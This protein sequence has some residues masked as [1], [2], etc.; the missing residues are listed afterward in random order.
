MSHWIRNCKCL[1]LWITSIG[2]QTHVF[3]QDKG[4]FW[5]Q[6]RGPNRDNM[7]IEEGLLQQWQDGGPP[8]AWRVSGI[9][10]G[11]AAVAVADRR[12]I[13]AGCFRNP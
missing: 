13:T 12:V 11:I 2:L 10:E 8:L 7:S 5:P 1:I 4:G 6:W 3:C 9:G